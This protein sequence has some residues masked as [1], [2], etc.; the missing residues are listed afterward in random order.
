MA[1]HQSDHSSH[2][3]SA[4]LAPKSANKMA[5]KN[6]ATQEVKK[7]PSPKSTKKSGDH[8]KLIAPFLL[9]ATIGIS[10]LIILVNS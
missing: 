3:N 8:S 6:S 7:S 2:Q 1:E 4:E 10:L 9:L 5:D